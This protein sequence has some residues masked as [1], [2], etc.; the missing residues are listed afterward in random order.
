MTIEYIPMGKLL[1][2]KTS[3]ERKIALEGI[4]RSQIKNHERH[5][6]EA[7]NDFLNRYL[8]S[9]VSDAQ[10]LVTACQATLAAM[11]DEQEEFRNKCLIY[12]RVQVYNTSGH[13]FRIE[14]AKFVIYRKRGSHEVGKTTVRIPSEKLRYPAQKFKDAPLWALKVILEY[15]D[16]F[17][18]IRQ[19]YGIYKEIKRKTESLVRYLNADLKDSASPSDSENPAELFVLKE[20]NKVD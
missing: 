16:K 6:L 4:S 18:F 11:N 17:V 13:A 7:A 14:W 20:I 8:V 19:K 3:R 9:L 5:A 10:L 12:P 1:L 2:A 15:E